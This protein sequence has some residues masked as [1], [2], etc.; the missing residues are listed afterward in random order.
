MSDCAI[1]LEPPNKTTRFPSC[2]ASCAT[3]VCRSCL[4]THLLTTE[5]ADPVCVQTTCRRPWT[6]AF[7]YSTLTSTFR[8]GPYKRLREKVL[9]D[10]E[11]ARLPDTQEDAKRYR[12]ALA[13][14]TPLQAEVSRLRGLI[15]DLP[16]TA[17]RDTLAREFKEREIALRKLRNDPEER[18]LYNL[19]DAASNAHEREEAPI[20]SQIWA[21]RRGRPDGKL[22]EAAR[23][24]QARL[25]AIMANL[26][27]A[28]LYQEARRS[29]ERRREEV[30]ALLQPL[31]DAWS[32]GGATSKLRRYKNAE[33]RYQDAAEPH[34]NQL[35]TLYETLAEP[36]Y[37][38][39]HYG[40]MPPTRAGGA[41]A[42]GAGAG[43]AGEAVAGA[44]RRAFLMKCPA[45][46]CGGFL[47][48]QYK[49]GLCEIQICA[50]CHV[51]KTKDEEHTCDSATVETIRQIRREAHPCPSCASLISKVDGCDQMWCTQCKTAFSWNT[52]RIETRAIHN[53]HFFQHMRETGQAIPRR[54][55]PGFGCAGVR[56]L[57]YT[58]NALHRTVDLPLITEVTETYR[59]LTHA[60][61]VDLANYR[62]ELTQFAEEE[63]RRILRVKRLVNEIDDKEWGAI[64]QRKEKETYKNTAWVHLLEMYTTVGL[65]TLGRITETSTEADVRAT[66]AEYQKVKAYTAEQAAAIA[67][68]YG[69]VLPFSFRP[70]VEEAAAATN[71]VVVEA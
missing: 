15:T 8:T 16:E 39:A 28:R 69:C 9:F 30:Q 64:L 43:G 45:S 2:C 65:E 24:E 66:Y 4:Q 42:G 26:P 35:R 60:R 14:Q 62:R 7:L 58:L 67:K 57:L 12:D 17:E 49:C 29:L 18:R 20:R 70:K 32:T 13:L 5:A 47:S 55:N 61:E 31:Y 41:G 40:Q 6:P 23:V 63:W 48:T 10:R 1:C 19:R 34:L 22:D 3:V 53:P 33:K 68:L 50:H 71:V 51:T 27:S 46:E 25:V 21:L 37:V 59:H 11:K 36:K 44:E 52:G 38:V 56:D 54:D